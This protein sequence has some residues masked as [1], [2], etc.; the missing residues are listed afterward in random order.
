MARRLIE[1]SK[2]RELERQ[3][4]ILDRLVL[5]FRGRIRSE[6]S[7][8]MR[9]MLD[10]WDHTRE[11]VMPREFKER[12][13]AT[14]HQMATAAIS[15]FGGRILDQGKSAGLVLERKEDFGQTMRQMALGY[16]Q[17]ESIRRRIT[18]V[19]ETTRRQIINA[20]DAGYRAG[21]GTG[22]IAR[23]IRPLISDIAGVR[24][25]TIARTETHGAA[26]YGSD[27]AAKLTGLP[28]KRE[29][30]AAVDER[31]RPSHA[32]AAGQD[33]VGMEEPFKVG[34]ALLM[35]PGDPS[36]PAGEVINCRCAV[37]Y[38]VQDGLD[39]EPPPPELVEAPGP[40]FAYENF[41]PAETIAEAVQAMTSTVARTVGLTR[42]VELAG[43]NAAHQAMME[44]LERFG[45]KP[46]NFVGDPSSSTF[47]YRWN[48]QTPA[49]F[50]MRTNEY[51]AK[52]SGFS[53]SGIAQ[54]F[55]LPDDYKKSL[56]KEAAFTVQQ[57]SLVA[58]EVKEMFKRLKDT[59]YSWS[60]VR[61]VRGVAMH[62]M[63]HKLHSEHLAE[64]NRLLP[65]QSQGWH[66]LLS[67]YAKVDADELF[68][69]S[70]AL[71]MLRDS[72]EHYRIYPPILDF[73]KRLDKKGKLA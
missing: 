9:D 21:V 27:Q 28:L 48:S 71:Y 5:Q 43:V 19:T 18:D 22:E 32:E 52:K 67:K 13:V 25:D 6:L 66:Y 56:H 62:E 69:E 36:G 49:A 47:N 51:L 44:A 33:P 64:V 38:I 45:L 41:K 8:A 54:K 30:I 39:E 72:S 46:M 16:I 1:R 7:A 63:G 26:N 50:G 17:Q 57:S 20:V 15:A 40:Q 23:T 42:G 31:T 12:M 29:W 35:Y 24:A 37:G 14:Y 60:Q 53:V 59:D 58:P 10:H 3:N 55:D 70:F 34:D 73:L 11:I 2:T 65:P 61:D 68:A 4:V